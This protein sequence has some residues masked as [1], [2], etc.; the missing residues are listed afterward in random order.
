M[1][2][3]MIGC[4]VLAGFGTLLVLRGATSAQIRLADAMAALEHRPVVTASGPGPRDGLAD[5]LQRRW[6]PLTTRQQQL[7]TVQGRS[8]GDFFTEKLVWTITGALLPG[9]WALVHFLVGDSPGLLPLGLSLIGAMLG[10]FVADVRLARSAQRHHRAATDGI[11][12]FFDLAVLERLANASASQATA[13]AAA[14]SDLPLFRRIS[15]GLE[16][17]R[18]EQ[19]QPWDELRQI[20][21]QWDIQELA[22]FADVMQLEE[23][24]TGLAEA[25][26]ARARELRD[27]HLSR[28]R[29]EAHRDS[30]AMTL[31][32]TIPALLLGLAVLI[33][34]L[35]GLSSL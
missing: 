29:A 14:V 13:N 10:Y 18:M 25:L 8:I 4:G 19:V 7:L 6:L 32:M 27:D 21:K 2:A 12:T 3:L 5:R 20:A 35:L 30:E 11:H 15:A 34:P 26:Q 22:D 23:Q 31:W 9:L 33:P 24:G 17:A 1:I 28:Q 16:R